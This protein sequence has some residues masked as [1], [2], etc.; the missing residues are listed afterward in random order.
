[1]VKISPATKY[2][3]APKENVPHEFPVVHAIVPIVEPFFL[4]IN[5]AFPAAVVFARTTL[6]GKP[7]A[8]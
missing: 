8:K 6:P 5:V 1:M 3:V 2:T 4:I 7:A